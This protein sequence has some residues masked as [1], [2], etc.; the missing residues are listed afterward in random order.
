MLCSQPRLALQR[1]TR[2]TRSTIV[3]PRFVSTTPNLFAQKD[4]QDK[5][6]LK[7]RSTEYSKTGSDD[8][9][10]HSDAAFNPN[11]TSPE[12]AEATA[13]REEGGN[14]LNVSPSNEKISE[15]NHQKTDGHGGG[16]DK[17]QSG[18][19]SAP[20]FGGNQSG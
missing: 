20:K 1:L 10:A 15:P 17:K 7:P 11:K 4:A 12:E 9:A 5:D 6:S 13:E 18:G 8:A 2:A 3:A 14:S 16:P 19:G